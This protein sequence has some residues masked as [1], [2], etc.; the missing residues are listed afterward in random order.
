MA[1]MTPLR[2]CMIDNMT[3]R[4]LSP[5]NQQSYVYG[6]PSRTVSSA[7]RWISYIT[8]RRHKRRFEAS[9]V[10]AGPRVRTHFPPA[11]SQFKPDFPPLFVP[12][13]QLGFSA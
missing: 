8:L 4:N 9:P 5:A 3:V 12:N 10:L 11:A 6:Q 2:R 13:P 1:Q 7:S